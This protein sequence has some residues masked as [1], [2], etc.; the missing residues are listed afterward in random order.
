MEIKLVSQTKCWFTHSLTHLSGFAHLVRRT[1]SLQVWCVL[2]KNVKTRPACDLLLDK[3]S[4]GPS[5]PASYPAYA[6]ARQGLPWG[7]HT[8][9][10]KL[11]PAS[12]S[13]DV[14]VPATL[15]VS[16]YSLTFPPLT[17]LTSHLTH[18]IMHCFRIHLCLYTQLHGY[19]CAIFQKY[20]P[21][22]PFR[23][24]YMTCV[25]HALGIMEQHL[26]HAQACQGLS[27]QCA[28][29]Y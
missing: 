11:E 10:S 22:V 2:L 7:S 29:S 25:T 27:D 16:S 3:T 19:S 28:S 26:F 6:A 12:V 21:N 9:G 14:A 17:E 5:R 8:P 4:V 20:M 24:S 18:M 23:A 13:L 1:L 15:M